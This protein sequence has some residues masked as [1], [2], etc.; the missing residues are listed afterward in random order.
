M[1]LYENRHDRLALLHTH[2]LVGRSTNPV[3]YECPANWLRLCDRCHM[4]YHFGGRFDPWGK[5]LPN[6]RREH[7][8]WVKKT[9]EPEEWD[10]AT[11]LRIMGRRDDAQLEIERPPE[12]FFDERRMW[13]RKP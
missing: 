1:L 6:L 10:E 11:L 2:H 9:D 7:L 4:H 12:S 3:L 5:R 8:L 13:S